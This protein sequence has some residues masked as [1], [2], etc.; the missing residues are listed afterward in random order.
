MQNQFSKTVT[1]RCKEL[2]SQLE[3]AHKDIENVRAELENSKKLLEDA[4]TNADQNA[5]KHKQEMS[6][7]E[8]VVQHNQKELQDKNAR[9]DDKV[10]SL[11]DEQ[12]QIS[13]ERDLLTENRDKLKEERDDLQKQVQDMCDEND[14]MSS[15]LKAKI[16]EAEIQAAGKNHIENEY[17]HLQEQLRDVKY[18]LHNQLAKLK[19]QFDSTCADK[20]TLESESLAK[21]QQVKQYKKQVDHYKARLHD[22]NAKIQLELEQC[23]VSNILTF[24]CVFSFIMHTIFMLI[25]Q[26]I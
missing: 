12:I 10:H 24:L 19:Q 20:K 18:S 26:K 13:L 5:E 16:K 17:R 21:T 23:R 3:K 22:S 9:L 2:Q 8:Q 6:D 7:I 4:L 15:E 14:R 1:E 25:K 11:E